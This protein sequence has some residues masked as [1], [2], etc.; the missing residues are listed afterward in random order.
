MSG[1]PVLHATLVAKRFADGWRGVLLRGP[2]GAGKSELALRALDAGFR[3]VA[4]DRVIVWRS[5]GRLF[6]RAPPVLHG[7]LEARR[8]DVLRRGALTLAPLDAVVDLVA[9]EPERLQPPSRALVEGLPLPCYALR[10]D[11]PSAPAELAEILAA[12]EPARSP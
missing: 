6:G 9:E 3:L 12:R 10:P 8:L 7:L 4:D 5:G 1:A 2:S 11:A